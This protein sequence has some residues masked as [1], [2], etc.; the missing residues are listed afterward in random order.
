LAGHGNFLRKRSGN[1]FY[2]CGYRNGAAF[3]AQQQSVLIDACGRVIARVFDAPGDGAGIPGTVFDRKLKRA[4]LDNCK[5]SCRAFNRRGVYYF[6]FG[7][8]AL[9]VKP[10]GSA[11]LYRTGF[12]KIR[13]IHFVP[14][15]GNDATP[16]GA[17]FGICRGCP[18]GQN[19]NFTG[20]SFR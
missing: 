1:P 12:P 17:I 13:L 15:D 18:A 14:R 9:V 8:D 2:L 10:D 5:L 16:V 7:L 3:Y 19:G 20:D 6:D 11:G 4:A